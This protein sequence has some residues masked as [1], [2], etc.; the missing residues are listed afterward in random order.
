MATSAPSSLSQSG[1][2]GWRAK[3]VSPTKGKS[4]RSGELRLVVI[5]N[6]LGDD[7]GGTFPPPSL[8]RIGS[9]DFVGNAFAFIR[10]PYRRKRRNLIEQ[11]GDAGARTWRLAHR[12]SP[13]RKHHQIKVDGTQ[14]V[15][16]E[17]GTI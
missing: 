1:Q 16:E 17:E 3:V 7:G 12:A 9:A 14:L 4:I 11:L 5:G 13:A 8:C 2:A 10:A 15:A 6:I